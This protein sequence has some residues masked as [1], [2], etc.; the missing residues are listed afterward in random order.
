MENIILSEPN[1]A[2]VVQLAKECGQL[3]RLLKLAKQILL[4]KYP[5]SEA[6]IKHIEIQAGICIDE[7]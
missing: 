4:A 7:L 5:D 3:A 2:D 1:A 6:E